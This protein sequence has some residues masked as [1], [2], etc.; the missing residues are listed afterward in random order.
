MS[1]IQTNFEE[2]KRMAKEFND[3][4]PTLDREGLEKGMK[5]LAVIATA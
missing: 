5:R 1:T 2:L 4:M 3:V